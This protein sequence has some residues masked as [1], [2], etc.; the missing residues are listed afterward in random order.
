MDC[1]VVTF[2]FSFR[3]GAQEKASD[4]NYF[5]LV[6]CRRPRLVYAIDVYASRSDPA[7]FCASYLVP[8]AYAMRRSGSRLRLLGVSS[9]RATVC[10]LRYNF[11]EDLALARSIFMKQELF[12]VDCPGTYPSYKIG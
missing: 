7:A 4:R 2:L 5:P 10:Q 8:Q 1:G 11:G 3:K 12:F 6:M 9:V